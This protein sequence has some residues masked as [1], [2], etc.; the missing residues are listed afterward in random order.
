MLNLGF[1]TN[2]EDHAT[3]SQVEDGVEAVDGLLSA[4]ATSIESS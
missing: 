1:A 4:T 3:P 2:V